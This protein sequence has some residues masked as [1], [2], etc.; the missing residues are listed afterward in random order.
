MIGLSTSRIA[1]FLYH[2]GLLVPFA[3]CSASN[4]GPV[5]PPGSLLAACREHCES[6]GD[7]L[8]PARCDVNTSTCA[9]PAVACDPLN[10]SSTPTGSA[11]SCDGQQE[12]DL[13]TSTCTPRPGADCQGDGDC[14][15]GEV[16]GGAT[17]VPGGSSALC[18]RDGDCVPPN[19]C[20]LIL[21]QADKKLVSICGTPVGPAEAGSRCRD[22]GECQ[23]GLCLRGGVCFGGCDLGNETSARTD[24]HGHAGVI[25]GQSSLVLPLGSPG[26]TMSF[27]ITGCVL[28]P[29][30][31]QSDRDC[32]ASGGAC[33][34]LVDAKNSG[35]LRTGCLPA[36]GQLRAGAPCERD[37]DCASA[38]CTSPGTG[39]PRT[40]F[41]ACRTA[42]E[43][44]TGLVCRAAPYQIDGVSGSIMS[45]VPGP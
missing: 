34:I 36:R 9:R 10:S 44:R 2:L 13:I 29:P 41:A 15:A 19:V 31:C 33:Q 21:D 38:L 4:Q 23:S 17:C 45:C 12:C 1:A 25:C 16:C 6:D 42:M 11:G 37:N 27:P 18:Q 39:T 43:C 22:N 26:M 24:C 32:D 7:C 30:A 14:R 8:A 35:Q 3:A 5:C 20:R 28:L 40:C